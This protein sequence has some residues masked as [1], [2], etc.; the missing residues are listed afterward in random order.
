MAP[1]PRTMQD[2]LKQ[3]LSHIS[4]GALSMRTF[5]GQDRSQIPHVYTD[6]DIV[7][8]TYSTL[9]SDIKRS[10]VLFQL[11]WFRVVLDE[12]S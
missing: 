3:R 9:M 4:P 12:G 8:T 7:L 6:V 5:H 11:Y 10:R 1:T 2:L